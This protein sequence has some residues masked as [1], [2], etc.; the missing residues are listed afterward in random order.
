MSTRNP[1]TR[2]LEV[3]EEQF[4]VFEKYLNIL[5]SAVGIEQPRDDLEPTELISN[6]KGDAA[7]TA[8]SD[9]YDLTENDLD[10]LRAEAEYWRDLAKFKHA[11]AKAMFS[12]AKAL[13]AENQERFAA[14]RARFITQHLTPR[15]SSTETRFLCSQLQS[16]L[17]LT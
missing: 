1:G 2:N 11:E 7:T 15:Q 6:F 12:K 13:F 4:Q 16:D 8:N 14:S 3:I 9:T 17:T 10:V 5:E